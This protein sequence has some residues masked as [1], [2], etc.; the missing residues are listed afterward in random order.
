MLE[1]LQHFSMKRAA[2][3]MESVAEIIHNGH[4]E[5]P[6]L[7]FELCLQR[8]SPNVKCLFSSCLSPS[9][10]FHGEL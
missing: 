7:C 6:E 5:E 10:F 1:K 8:P 9:I 3:I 4:V 2:D